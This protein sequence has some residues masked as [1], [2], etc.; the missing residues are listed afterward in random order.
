VPKLSWHVRSNL[1]ILFITSIASWWSS[2]SPRR[3]TIK[4]G[5]GPVPVEDVGEDVGADLGRDDSK[6]EGVGLE[7]ELRWSW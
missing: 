2:G 5:R 7:V 3:A 6:G 1:H 4:G